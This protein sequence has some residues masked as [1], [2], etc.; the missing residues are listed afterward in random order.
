MAILQ[1]VRNHE[2]DILIGTQMVA[3]GLHFP[4]MTLVGVVWADSGLGMPDYKASER[5]FQL[6][7]QVTGRAGRGEHAGKVIIQTNQPGHYAIEFA[8]RHEYEKLYE[9]EINLRTSL[10]YPP[11]SRLVNVRFSGENEERVAA[12]AKDM[13]RFLR[14]AVSSTEIEILGPAPSP[15]AR[16]K[17]RYRWQLLLKSRD[18]LKL[19]A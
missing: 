8:Q 1:Q 9:Q 4:K 5:T 19:H 17:N 16:I 10:N 3:K 2:V 12:T 13:A 11:F 15:L 14:S 7:A 6:L 18:Y